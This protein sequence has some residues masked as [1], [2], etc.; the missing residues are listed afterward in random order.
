MLT[1]L[2]KIFFCLLLIPTT[3]IAKTT[4]T[5]KP[6][7]P[8]K[9]FTSAKTPIIGTPV[10][11]KQQMIKFLLKKNPDAKPFAY[12][13]SIFLDEGRREGVRGDVAF[14]QSILE[15]NYFRFNNDTQKHQ[16]NFA[17]IGSVKKGVRGHSYA[18]PR[19]GIRAQIQHLKAYASR[20]NLRQPLIDVRFHFAR[21]Q[22]L[23]PYVEDLGGL[24]ACPGYDT[25]KHPSLEVAKEK[26][27]SYGD[28]IVRLLKAIQETK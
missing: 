20:E 1:T 7:T 26:K 25:N 27:E 13:V 18:S 10:C 21:K 9:T 8:Q 6:I 23:C 15:T 22:C 16:N 4:R 11:T 24:W 5:N 19:E 14:A 3:L 28:H 2:I 12:H 17:G